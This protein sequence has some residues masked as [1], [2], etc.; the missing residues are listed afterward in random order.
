[1]RRVFLDTVGLLATWDV[2]DQWHVDAEAAMVELMKS[3]CE[4]FTSDSVLLEC[5]NASA[6]NAYRGDVTELRT[7]LLAAGRVLSP[8][9]SE[10]ETAWQAYG[11]NCLPVPGLSIRS[12][13]C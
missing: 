6:R 7:S 1:M 3:P 8:S 2:A 4:L 9:E 13:S 5:G 10:L 12:R 11:K